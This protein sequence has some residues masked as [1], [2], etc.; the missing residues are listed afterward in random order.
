MATFATAPP[1]EEIVATAAAPTDT[2]RKED[3]LRACAQ[4]DVETLRTILADAG[5]SREEL[6]QAKTTV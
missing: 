4:E 1:V 2:N 6:L 5:S 3:F